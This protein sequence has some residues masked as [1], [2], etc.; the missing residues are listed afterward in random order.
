MTPARAYA[1][2]RG[3]N[4]AQVAR[5]V[6]TVWWGTLTSGRFLSGWSVVVSFVIAVTVLGAYVGV[7]TAGEYVP[8]VGISALGWALLVVAMLPVAWGERRLGSPAARAA[9]LLSAIVVAGAARPVLNDALGSLLLGQ[10][11]AA[12]WTPRILTNVLSWLLVLS[13]VAIATTGYGATRT[14][15]GR[16]RVALA[17]LREADLR[18]DVFARRS[19]QR[20]VAAVAQLRSKLDVLVAGDPDFDDVREFSQA[21]R[22]ESHA[23]EDAAAVPLGEVKVGTGPV[24][25]PRRTPRPFLSRVRP[26]APLIVSIIYLI[27]SLPYTLDSVPPLLVIVAAVI[28]L[29]MGFAADVVSRRYARRRSASARGAAVIVCWSVAGALFTACAA[30]LAPWTWPVPLVPLVVFPG[31]AII[32]GIS[33]DALRRSIVQT[34]KL[35]HALADQTDA[36]AART[37]HA[38]HALRVAAEQLHGHVQGRCVLFAAGLEDRPATPDEAA[39]FAAAVERAFADIEDAPLAPLVRADELAEM[40]ETWSH[41]LRIDSVIDGRARAAMADERVSR[42]VIDIASEGFLN[43]VKHS[44]AREAQLVVAVDADGE[45]SVEVVSPGTLGGAL[46]LDHGRGI[47]HLGIGARVYQRGRDV[48]LDARIPLVAV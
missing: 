40:L 17:D 6:G 12:G 37:A 22:E 38:R 47:L 10:A 36:V 24:E 30:V 20:L 27:V 18:A 16:L 32:T 14:A 11:S 21:V 35:T 2:L 45:L 48:V 28:V 13:L 8:A 23:L 34:R 25:T 31:I 19:R 42:R 9:L 39:A 29:V 41:V 4:P 46:P 26:P 3:S 5:M 33:S 44:G 15:A 7:D 1:D 43:A